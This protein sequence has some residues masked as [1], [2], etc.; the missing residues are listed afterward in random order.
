M[1]SIET[2]AHV[3]ENLIA[4]EIRSANKPAAAAAYYRGQ[5]LGRTDATGVYGAY[6]SGGTGGLE[7][8]QAVCT[9]DI[10]VGASG[11]IPVFITGSEVKGSSLKASNGT[12]LT[13]TV[14]IVEL[15]QDAG[16]IIR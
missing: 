1:A 12:A 10:T 16:I 3:T 13:V 7:K 5:L 11:I 2:V 6:N 15:A 9:S 14:A 8:I 4:G